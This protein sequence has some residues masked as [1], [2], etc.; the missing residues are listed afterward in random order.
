MGQPRPLF[1]L[2]SVFFKQTL[3]IFTTNICE[4]CPSSLR[5]RDSNPRPLER[6]S[7]PIATRPGLP[8]LDIWIVSGTNLNVAISNNIFPYLQGCLPLTSFALRYLIKIFLSMP[9]TSLG[10]TLFKC[11]CLNVY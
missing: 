2:F 6:E 10:I 9:Q 5:C 7:P 1:H 11:V 3:Q 8:P 4:K